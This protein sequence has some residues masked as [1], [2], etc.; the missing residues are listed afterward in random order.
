MSKPA[1][2]TKKGFDSGSYIPLGKK[3]LSQAGGGGAT[4]SDAPTASNITKQASSTNLAS[5]EAN[6]VKTATKLTSSI[7]TSNLV[8]PGSNAPTNNS[9]NGNGS[10]VPSVPTHIIGLL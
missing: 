1:K 4:A 8:V 9:N 10:V 7:S 3:E 6:V 2:V 5:L